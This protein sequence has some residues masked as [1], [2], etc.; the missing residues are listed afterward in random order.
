MPSLY[1]KNHFDMAGFLVGLKLHQ[2]NL[3]VK[4]NDLIFGLK[5]NGFH[6]N[7]YSLIR[8][9]IKDHKINL[10]KTMIGKKN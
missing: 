1:Q 8:K 2:K 5:S 3:K 9:I 6:S 4:K 10:K 7:G